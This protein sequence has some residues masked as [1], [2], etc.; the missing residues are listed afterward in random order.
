[1]SFFINKLVLVLVAFLANYIVAGCVQQYVGTEKAELLFQCG[2]IA[3]PLAFFFNMVFRK[4]RL[5]YVPM[6]MYLFC[7]FI[8]FNIG[9][10][11]V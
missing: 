7:L 8:V 1:V 10:G 4:Y 3:I 6:A 2:Q 9:G 5:I 11:G